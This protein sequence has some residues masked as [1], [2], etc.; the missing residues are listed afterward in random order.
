M[1]YSCVRLYCVIHKNSLLLNQHNGDDAPQKENSTVKLAPSVPCLVSADGGVTAANGRFTFPAAFQLWNVTWWNEKYLRDNFKYKEWRFCL[2][3]LFWPQTFLS[4]WHGRIERCSGPFCLALL[5]VVVI[6]IVCVCVCGQRK[7]RGQTHCVLTP[8]P[9]FGIS[10][11]AK[12]KMCSILSSCLNVWFEASVP[13]GSLAL[14]SRR[15]TTQKSPVLVWTYYLGFWFWGAS[16]PLCW[17]NNKE[18]LCITHTAEHNYI[19]S[20]STVGIQ[21]HVSALYVGHLQVVI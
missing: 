21:L 6:N 16:S 3:I 18:F 10:F 2:R 14:R 20:S 7:T 19:S 1:K 12:T 5:T 4:W 17:F 8:S 13:P 9:L 15:V 11:A